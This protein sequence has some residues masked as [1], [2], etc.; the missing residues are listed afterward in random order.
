MNHRIQGAARALRAF[1]RDVEA[2]RRPGN[3]LLSDTSLW[4]LAL[5]RGGDALGAMTGRRFGTRTLLRLFFHID[6]WTDDV[7]GGLRLPHPFN[8]VIGEGVDIEPDCVLMH[9][10]TVQR[11]DGTRLGAGSFVGAGATVLAGVEVGARATVG[12][13]AV[14]TRSVV[15]GQ[16]VAGVPARPTNLR[17]AA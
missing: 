17:E 11:G 7:G 15:P 1:R 5:L 14:V 10:V 9:G 13:G 3:A 16:V 2:A 8:I 4:A 12:A 6:V